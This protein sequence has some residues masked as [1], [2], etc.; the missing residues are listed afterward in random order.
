MDIDQYLDIPSPM[1]GDMEIN[2]DGV[3]TIECEEIGENAEIDGNG[4]ETVIV[5]GGTLTLKS[6]NNVWY[7]FV[8]FVEHCCSASKTGCGVS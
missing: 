7:G 2:L 4:L 6:S 5:D 8:C 3:D 1:T